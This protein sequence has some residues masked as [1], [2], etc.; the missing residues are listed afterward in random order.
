MVFF[1]RLYISA[2]IY[3]KILYGFKPGKRSKLQAINPSRRQRQRRES[4]CTSDYPMVL[5]QIPMYNERKVY[6]LSIGAVCRLS[7]PSDRI[8]VQVL[9]DSTD[10][11]IKELVAIECQRWEK[12]GINIKHET[13]VHR[14]GY[15]AGAL[16][17]GLKHSY[18]EGC[19][20]VAIFD[21]DFQ[22]EPDYLYR[23]VPYLI[24]NP[25]IG[26]VQTK[27]DFGNLA[28]SPPLTNYT[29]LF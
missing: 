19:K 8:I 24:H 25:E 7:W 16:Q 27:W 12:E 1:E 14:N 9:D 10:H 29:L 23:T 26:L 6:K 13:R 2:I 20:F 28:S 11:L 3:Y 18:V 22:P 21:A 4:K 5:V 15:K 17:E